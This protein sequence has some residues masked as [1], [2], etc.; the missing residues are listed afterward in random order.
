MLEHLKFDLLKLNPMLC[1]KIDAII[2]QHINEE[3]K[4]KET[5]KNLEIKVKEKELDLKS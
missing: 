2:A 3:Q 4:R 1:D 5:Q